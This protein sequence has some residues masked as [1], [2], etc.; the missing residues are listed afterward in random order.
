[1]VNLLL[2]LLL[3]TTFFDIITG[4]E[5]A[6]PYRHNSEN[7]I[8]YVLGNLI[9]RHAA[10]ANHQSHQNNP[11]SLNNRHLFPSS[12][13]NRHSIPNLVFSYPR[14]QHATRRPVPLVSADE[15]RIL[16]FV[17]ETITNGTSDEE[18]EE[19]RKSQSLKDYVEY[20]RLYSKILAGYEKRFFERVGVS[21]KLLRKNT[22]LLKDLVEKSS[23]SEGSVRIEKSL[24]KDILK[25]LVR[26]S[27]SKQRTDLVA[28]SSHAI[29]SRTT[30]SSS[31]RR[32][33]TSTESDESKET[34]SDRIVESSTTASGNDSEDSET[35]ATTQAADDS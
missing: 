18:Q 28:S 1:M 30:S 22:F 31:T 13:S 9:A 4:A 34:T 8:E 7:T 33:V 24:L 23:L 26:L 25:I 19:G 14:R 10:A 32:I 20:L 16:E 5:A 29:P 3:T 21:N 6:V 35:G 2:A 17:I 27:E 12:S 15:N 11:N